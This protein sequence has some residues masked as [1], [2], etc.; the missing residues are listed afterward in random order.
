MRKN[1]KVFKSYIHPSK[2]LKE[3][4]L[5]LREAFFKYEKWFE[6]NRKQMELDNMSVYKQMFGRDLDSALNQVT[7]TVTKFN[8]DMSL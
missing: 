7:N 1:Y 4:N 5:L 2:L 3:K 6:T 8:D